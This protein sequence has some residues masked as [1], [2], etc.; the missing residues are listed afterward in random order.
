[1]DAREARRDDGGLGGLCRR[2]L[3]CVGKLSE[4]EQKSR[5]KNRRESARTRPRDRGRYVRV[6]S[7]GTRAHGEMK[8]AMKL[9]P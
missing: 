2:A 7:Q 4:V 9:L 5:D 6:E 3:G 8:N 1:M